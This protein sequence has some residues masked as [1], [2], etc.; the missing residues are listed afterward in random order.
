MITSKEEKKG[1]LQWKDADMERFRE[2]QESLK[3][4][5]IN[6]INGKFTWNNRRGGS[7][8]IASRLERFLAIEQFL[9]KK[10]FMKQ[11]SYLAKD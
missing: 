2:T 5:D 6:T 10:Y 4:I 9:G 11:L 3:M 8:Q 1:G 7:R